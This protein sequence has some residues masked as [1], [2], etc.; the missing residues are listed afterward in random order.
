MEVTWL[1][2][3][4]FRLQA[5]GL[6]ILTDPFDLPPQTPLQ[7]G[8]VVTVSRR[9][10][11]ERLAVAEVYRLVAGP[12]EFEIRGVPFTGIATTLSELSSPVE[13]ASEAAGEAGAAGGDPSPGATVDRRN[14]IYT[15]VLE[16]ITVCHLGRLDRPPGAAQL[17]EMGT[18]D[19]VLILV[20]E[21]GGLGA[22]QA[23]QLVSQLEAKILLPVPVGGGQGEAAVERFCRELGADPQNVSPRLSVSASGL[24]AQTQVVRLAAVPLA[25]R[26]GGLDA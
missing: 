24:P 23:V 13:A 21:G 19:V 11:L 15:M 8:D 4:C 3:S 1:G 17:Q 22:P 7:S 25:T 10:P 16:G 12:G 2:G 26:G 20:G 18:P 6:R 14:V 5:S 9:V